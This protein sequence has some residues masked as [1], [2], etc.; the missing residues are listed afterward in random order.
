MRL[1]KT[2]AKLQKLLIRFLEKY[3]YKN[4]PFCIFGS[5]WISDYVTLH[6]LY[7][8]CTSTLA[9][10]RK[11]TDWLS[12]T[13]SGFMH[14]HIFVNTVQK[15]ES[16]FSLPDAAALLVHCSS[17]LNNLV[18]QLGLKFL[19]V[20]NSHLHRISTQW[21]NTPINHIAASKLVAL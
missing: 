6:L 21:I 2:E 9:L 1:W 16:E 4:E 11:S 17:K 10:H 20:D 19:K 13:C 8:Y 5:C 15:M 14:L 7:Q 12:E 18:H 3:M